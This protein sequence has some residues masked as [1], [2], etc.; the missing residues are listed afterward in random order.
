LPLGEL[1]KDILLAL[2][3]LAITPLSRRVVL[4][5]IV[6]RCVL[7]LLGIGKVIRWAIKPSTVQGM[8][9]NVP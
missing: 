8:F 2:V 1:L 9:Y 5:G 6:R 4:M 3:I 7:V